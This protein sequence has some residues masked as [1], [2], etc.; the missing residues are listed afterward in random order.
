MNLL[1]NKWNKRIFNINSSINSV[2]D[3][4]VY[5]KLVGSIGLVLEATGLSLPVGSV[6]SIS[7]TINSKTILAEGE[8]IGFK[9]N[10]TFIMLYKETEGLTPGS[11]IFLKN[12][13]DKTQKKLP[14]SFELLGRVLDGSANPLDNK[15]K[16][17][18][19]HSTSLMT[20]SINPLERS[21]IEKIL[22]VGVRS[23][24]TLL[25]IGRGQRIGLFSS[26]GLGKS[27]L[28][29]MI[30]KYAKADIVIVSLIGERGREIKEFIN[31]ILGKNYLPRSVVIASPADTSPLLRIQGAIYAT[32]IAE[33]FRDKNKHVLLIMDSLT[34]YAMAYREVALSI[35]ELPTTK[36][37]P[38]STYSKI[39]TLIE[40]A[41]NNKMKNGSIT[42][43][44]TLLTEIEESSD[45]IADLV[46]SI[47]DGHIIL[48]QKYAESG[49]Y[50]A[51][52][53]ERSISRI[54][55]D[56]VDEKT[57]RLSCYFKQIVASYYK[58]KDLINIGAYI[59]GND[60][61]LDI[62][63]KLWPKIERFL[64]QSIHFKENYND[65]L[66]LLQDILK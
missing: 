52:D 26:S 40:K 41:G 25:T 33:Y 51:I 3:F 61:I 23:I 6:C 49:C 32:R 12:V 15:P 5:G 4:F 53:I 34:R 31:K 19:K 22:D 11:K 24:N 38:S 20:E 10:I 48:S 1:L 2:P 54:M 57:Y 64:R 42:A 16:L 7:N 9:K 58:N 44:Y 13:F 66:K 63:I 50:P 45:P 59:K 36:G 18:I 43:F 28:I 17:N 37:Y 65:S 62:S 30:A 60:N 35:G 8:V 29:G 47:L 46:K 56:L 55:P 27:M 14:I 21:P 39:S